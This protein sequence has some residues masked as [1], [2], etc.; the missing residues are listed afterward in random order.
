MSTLPKE[1]PNFAVIVSTVAIALSAVEAW[2]R[3]GAFEDA[4][5]FLNVPCKLLSGTG[6]VGSVRQIG[7]AIIEVMVNAGPLFYAYAQNYGPMAA[8]AYHGSVSLEPTGAKSSR[9]TYT[10][11]YDQ[12]LMDESKRISEL[13]RITSRFQGAAESMRN[14]AEAA[15]GTLQ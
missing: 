11:L 9:L 14:V 12:S 1:P 13:A 8:Y 15:S 6:D 10:I 5:R 4:G 2:K 3:I 7:E